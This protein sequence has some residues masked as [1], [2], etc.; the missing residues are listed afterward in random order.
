MS[1][2]ITTETMNYPD[3]PNKIYRKK[4]IKFHRKMQRKVTVVETE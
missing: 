1:L 4:I 2:I 3:K